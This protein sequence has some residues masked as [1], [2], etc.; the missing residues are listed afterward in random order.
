M[1]F[2]TP[3]ACVD[4]QKRVSCAL[5]DCMHTSCCFAVVSIP[6]GY[7]AMLAYNFPKLDK[8]VKKNR[9]IKQFLVIIVWG[10]TFF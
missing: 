5:C 10:Y 6:V 7:D 1:G 2:S 3:A 9:L 4:I 8:S